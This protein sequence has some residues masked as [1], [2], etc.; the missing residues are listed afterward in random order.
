[1]ADSRLNSGEVRCIV[2][3][4]RNEKLRESRREA[5]LPRKTDTQRA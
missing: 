3:S 4:R 1:M 5:E 2:R